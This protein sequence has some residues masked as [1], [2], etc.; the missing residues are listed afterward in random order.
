MCTSI[1]SSTRKQASSCQDLRTASAS[2]ISA[3]TTHN[4][5]PTTPHGQLTE[6]AKGAGPVHGRIGGAGVCAGQSP[7]L[8]TYHHISISISIGPEKCIAS[9]PRASQQ[10][11]ARSRKAFGCKEDWRAICRSRQHH[12]Q[13]KRHPVVPRRQLLHGIF[14]ATYT[15]PN[16]F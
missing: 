4:I 5:T 8:T 11:K 16:P 3:I 2:S 6:I 12:L 14:T 13:A 7:H 1:D 9:S 10:G 15:Q